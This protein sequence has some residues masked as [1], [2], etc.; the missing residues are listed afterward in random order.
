MKSISI[1]R[2]INRSRSSGKLDRDLRLAHDGGHGHSFSPIPVR[3]AELVGS[4]APSYI[5]RL[6]RILRHNRLNTLSENLLA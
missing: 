3:D 6:S 2:I 4:T 5:V 1:E